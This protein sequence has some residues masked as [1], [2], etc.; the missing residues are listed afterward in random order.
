VAQIIRQR[1]T[2]PGRHHVGTPGDII[3]ECLGDFIGI[4]SNP[5]VPLHASELERTEANFAVL[6]QFFLDPSFV[7][8]AAA[9]TIKASRP[10]AMHPAV[11]V[12]GMIEQH[13]N[14]VA[15]CIPC[16][17]VAIIVESSQRADPVL[18]QHFGELRPQGIT[19]SWPVDYRLMPKSSR[20]PGLE[21]A[22][23]VVSAAG[24]QT[25]RIAEGKAGL[26]PDFRDVFGRL[27]PEGCLFSFV[28]GVDDDRNNTG[29]TSVRGIRLGSERT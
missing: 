25:K 4:R 6:S 16:D 24:S 22:D 7:R 27:P 8:I 12:M 10:T 18:R 13:I 2:G 3:S 19:R 21:I 15:S 17:G 14:A 1:G 11:P 28:E 9:S 29:L 23:F 26:A 5:D 20:E